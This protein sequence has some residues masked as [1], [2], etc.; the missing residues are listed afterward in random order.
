M[1][2]EKEPRVIW[3]A[4]DFEQ[5]PRRWVEAVHYDKMKNRATT[6]E[7]RIDAARE[8]CTDQCYCDSETVC[9]PCHI[10]NILEGIYETR[11]VTDQKS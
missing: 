3:Q 9:A 2:T 11:E 10:K 1:S 4:I 6:A 8:E 7:K 5:Y